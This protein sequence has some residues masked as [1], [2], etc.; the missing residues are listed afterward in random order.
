MTLC[1]YPDAHRTLPEWQDAVC[2]SNSKPVLSNG[3]HP[4]HGDITPHAVHGSNGNSSGSQ[5]TRHHRSDGN[6]GRPAGGYPH[7]EGYP[8]HGRPAGGYPHQIYD[9]NLRREMLLHV[10][11]S[12]AAAKS[13]AK[14]S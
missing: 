8:H 10:Y 14:A 4:M 13:E 1:F 2:A 7:V 9:T 11:E 12:F 5:H 3:S 6:H